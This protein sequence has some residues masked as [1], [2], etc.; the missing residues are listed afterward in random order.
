MAIDPASVP[1]AA[2]IWGN[3]IGHVDLGGSLCIF[4]IIFYGVYPSKRCSR[5][6]RQH[7]RWS[8]VV[9]MAESQFCLFTEKQSLLGSRDAETVSTQMGPEAESPHCCLAFSAGS[10]GFLGSVT[11][12]GTCPS[13]ALGLS[14]QGR[15]LQGSL[16]LALICPSVWGVRLSSI[17]PP[18][19]ARSWSGIWTQPEPLFPPL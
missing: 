2:P 13:P 19:H 3:T 11:L 10:R 9:K 6:W 5:P 8:D 18:P 14:D 16:L 1:K 17:P 12:L 15:W 4:P 7:R